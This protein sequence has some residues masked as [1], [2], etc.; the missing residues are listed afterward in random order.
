MK[1]FR[2]DQGAQA[3]ATFIGLA[4]LLTACQAGAPPPVARSSPASRPAVV[5]TSP[6][7]PTP[8]A[9]VAAAGLAR[10]IGQRLI[11][12]MDGPLASPALLGRIRRGEIG[13]VILFGRNITTRAALVALT[14]QLHLAAR[15]GGQPRFLIAVDQE[16][17]S[18]KRIPWAPPTLSPP[19]MG[20]LGS[21]L[22]AAGQGAATGRALAALGIDV[23]LAPV[24]DV[25]IS[26]SSFLERQ[27][28]IWS[29][30]ASR[31]A[32]LAD[33]FATGLESAG[34]VPA[35]K[36]FPGLGL[37]TENTDLRIVSIRATQTAL[38]PGLLPYRTAIRHDI[39]LIMLSNATYPAYDAHS[40]AGW[41][42]T[43]NT[44]LLRGA[45]GF[46]GV[47][48]TDALDGTARA[49]GLTTRH[50]AIRAAG[51]GTDL[52]L[53]T[54]SEATSQG[55]F[56][57]L[58]AAAAAGTIPIRGLSDSYARILALKTGI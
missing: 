33:A 41:S 5:S 48:I 2:I 29:F 36:H 9:P 57:A 13:G 44:G 3:R 34:I 37:A 51:A 46:R 4:L 49:R 18:I 52:L 26:T 54:G 11:V 55:V 24:A 45:L 25:P 42:P 23:D 31:T 1:T 19:E 30:S 17:G 6:S 10:L 39:P 58:M 56:V 43:I 14:R 16:G 8:G 21:T 50:L 12:A 40:A 53:I 22:I 20:R 7:T 38:L 32:S 28:R 15:S 35:L 47:T 27:G